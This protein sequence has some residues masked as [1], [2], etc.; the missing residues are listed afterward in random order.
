VWQPNY[1]ADGQGNWFL[2]TS[3]GLIHSCFSAPHDTAPAGFL[4][5]TRINLKRY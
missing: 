5:G 3:T 1:A 4:A 2:G